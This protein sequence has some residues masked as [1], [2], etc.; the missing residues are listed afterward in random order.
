NHDYKI[1]IDESVSV[2]NIQTCGKSLPFTNV[3]NK[4]DKKKW[5]NMFKFYYIEL[6]EQ[7]NKT[8][9]PPPFLPRKATEPG[10]H[11]NF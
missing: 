4:K 6:P 5:K 8:K 3:W 10:Y 1:N 2:N 11:L 7:C 9:I